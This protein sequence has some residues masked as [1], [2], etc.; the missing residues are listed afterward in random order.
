MAAIPLKADIWANIGLNGRSWPIA[1]TEI[2][3]FQTI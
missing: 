3:A 1:A 2:T